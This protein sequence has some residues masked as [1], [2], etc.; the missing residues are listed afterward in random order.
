MFMMAAVVPAQSP[1]EVAR[2]QQSIEGLIARSGA[3]VAVVWQPLDQDDPAHGIHLNATAGFHAASMMK[4]PVMVELFQQV[5]SGTFALEDTLVVSNRFRSIVDGS[6]YELAATEDSDREVYRAI[7]QPLSYRALCEAMITTSSNLAANLLIDRLGPA[8]IRRTTAGLGAAGLEVL[9]GVEDQKAFDR[10]L[11]NS[12]D[13]SSLATLFRRIGRH[14]AVSRSAS[15]AMVDILARQR[16]NSAIPAG[17]PEGTRVAHKTG[18]ITRI[19]HDGGIVF[20][21]RPYVLVVLTRGLDDA[22]EADA[23]IAAIA[24]AV[25]GLAR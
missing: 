11:N 7:G 9:R 19:R 21:T 12:T 20:A 16:F 4:V 18:S 10:G 8:E 15:A 6:L 22:R 5:E 2:V 25:D 3:E 1:T 17:L 14:E 23:L 13:A 24:T